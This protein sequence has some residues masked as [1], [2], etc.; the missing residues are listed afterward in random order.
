[1]TQENK[2][3]EYLDI[4]NDPFDNPEWRAFSSGVKNFVSAVIVT[5]HQT[6]L[7]VRSLVARVGQEAWRPAFIGSMGAMVVAAFWVSFVV[8]PYQHHTLPEYFYIQLNIAFGVMLGAM[9][10]RAW[11]K[12]ERDVTAAEQSNRLELS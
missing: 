6:Y 12:R 8:L 9:G 7:H 11:E 5:A 10:L 4:N 3:S 1:M 2:R